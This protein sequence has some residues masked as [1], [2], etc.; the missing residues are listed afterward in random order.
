MR[1]AFRVS[2]G[3]PVALSLPPAIAVAWAW[4]DGG[5]PGRVAVDAL[6]HLPLVVPPVVVGW[7]LLMLFGRARPGRAPRSRPGSAGASS[8][9]PLAPRWRRR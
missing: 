7:A 6:V 1:S 8:S 2:R 4:R 3:A 5:F 9:P